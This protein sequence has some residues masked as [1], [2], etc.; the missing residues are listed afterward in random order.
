MEALGS[1]SSSL[2]NIPFFTKSRGGM[3]S[4]DLSRQSA[5]EIDLVKTDHFQRKHIGPKM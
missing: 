1:A 3:I 5:Q 4:A 2:S